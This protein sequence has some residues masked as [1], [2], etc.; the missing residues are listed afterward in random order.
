M[1]S[2]MTFIC[3]LSQ[4]STFPEHQTTRTTCC[5]SL[6]SKI[7]PNINPTKIRVNESNFA[8]PEDF[9]KYFSFCS[10]TIICWFSFIELTTI[11]WF[12]FSSL[13][14]RWHVNEHIPVYARYLCW[15]KK[16]VI[17]WTAYGHR[18][19]SFLSFAW[20]LKKCSFW[21]LKKISI[22]ILVPDKIKVPN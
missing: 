4:M 9:Y 22:F 8:F 16:K 19:T 20:I 6:N 14:F 5:F 17:K 11:I 21:S 3:F 10:R 2:S 15:K 7:L 18:R 13:N 1:K 12:S